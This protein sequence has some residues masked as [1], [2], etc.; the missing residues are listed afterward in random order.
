MEDFPSGTRHASA[1]GLLTAAERL[2]QRRG[3]EPRDVEVPDEIKNLTMDA[4]GILGKLQQ[5]LSKLG[6]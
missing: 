3:M 2:A 5:A 6:S 1:D 4:K